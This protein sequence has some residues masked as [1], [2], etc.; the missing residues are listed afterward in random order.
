MRSIG[1]KDMET[2]KIS[3]MILEAFPV[4]GFVID[5]DH[6]ITHWNRACEILTNVPRQ[7]IVGT[8]NQWQLFYSTPR[9]VMADLD[10]RHDGNKLAD[11][12]Y[13][14]KVRHSQIIPG[15]YEAEDFFPRLGE[16]G[17]RWLYFT[18]TPLCNDH[19]TVIGAI[20]TSQAPTKPQ[21]MLEHRDAGDSV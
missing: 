11:D 18:A 17:G 6:R 1:W 4:A 5:D 9:M 15:T 12:L 8:S 19:G 21:Q 7:T 13:L 3:A 14:G 2:S 10:L 16:N 20:E